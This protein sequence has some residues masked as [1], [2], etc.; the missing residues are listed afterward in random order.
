MYNYIFRLKKIFLCN[1]FYTYIGSEIEPALSECWNWNRSILDFAEGREKTKTI[2]IY[3]RFLSLGRSRA[4]KSPIVF[5]LTFSG[6][7]QRRTAIVAD[8]WTYSIVSSTLTC[9]SLP[10]LYFFISPPLF[11][12]VIREIFYCFAKGDL[13][14][15][16]RSGAKESSAD[17]SYRRCWKWLLD[18]FVET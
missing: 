4:I 12:L 3:S 6:D 8:W 14:M 2:S 13:L 7:L 17:I 9:P 5:Y 11:I 18:V 15:R 10:L 16:F 1:F